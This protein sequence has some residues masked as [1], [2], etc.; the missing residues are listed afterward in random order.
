[1][2]KNY[3]S[4]VLEIG[5]YGKWV[6][7]E[8]VII[9]APTGTGKTTFI[10]KKLLPYC[11]SLDKKML[12]LCNRRLLSQ[13]YDFELVDIY[14]WYAEMRE[15]V[16]VMTYQYLS[17]QLCE[18]NGIEGM[19]REYDVVVCDE[20]HYFYNDVDF[21]AKGTYVLLQAIIAASFFKSIVMITA[22][23]EET[24]PIIENT[25][26][27]FQEWFLKKNLYFRDLRNTVSKT[28]F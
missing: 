3:I 16:D 28:R 1:M 14:E 11:K 22:T 21:N 6:H 9:S 5:T 17:G 2:E 8:K 25:F 7:G 13:Q 27:K 20:V 23:L 26:N 18:G 15:D 10:L 24:L 12:I 4:D 19:M